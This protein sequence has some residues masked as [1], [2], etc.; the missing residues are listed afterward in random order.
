MSSGIFPR[1][2]ED[3]IYSFPEP[4]LHLELN[5]KMISSNV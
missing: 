4:A 5:P 3:D 2:G 1:V